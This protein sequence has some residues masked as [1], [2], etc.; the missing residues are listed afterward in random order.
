MGKRALHNGPAASG[1]A[2]VF[3]LLI[4]IRL[5]SAWT[6]THAL[7]SNLSAPDTGLGS[8]RLGRRLQWSAGT[9]S[10]RTDHLRLWQNVVPEDALLPGHRVRAH[11]S[12]LG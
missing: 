12:T 3:D 1:F 8:P 9:P 4:W 11:L 6:P 7:Y 5:S 10:M 2:L